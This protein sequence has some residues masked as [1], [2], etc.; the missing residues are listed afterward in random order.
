MRRPALSMDEE[1]LYHG[2]A[3]VLASSIVVSRTC[4]MGKEMAENGE[5]AIKPRRGCWLYILLIVFGLPVLLVGLAFA[6]L[7][8][9]DSAAAARLE[10]RLASI[11]AQGLPVD[12]ASLNT[13]Y[14]SLTSTDQTDAWLAILEEL[15][16]EA[17]RQSIEG[18]PIFDGKL[19]ENELSAEP[20]QPWPAEARTR[21]FLEQWSGLHDRTMRL[22]MDGKPT[23]WDL[24]FASFSTS[25]E[26]TQALRSAGRLLS[27]RGQLGLYDR[28]P[29]AVRRAVDALLGIPRVLEGEPFM[30]SQLVATALKGMG[31]ELLKDALQQGV[32]REQDL[33]ALLPKIIDRTKVGGSWQLSL[34]GER[35]M[36]LPVVRNPG[37]HD[38]GL[39]LGPRLP[40]RSNDANHYLDLLEDALEIHTEDPI[41]LYTKARELESKMNTEL[42]NMN[43]FEQLDNIMTSMVTPAIAAV[44]SAYS[45]SAIQFRIT[46]LAMAVRMYELEH[47]SLPE[48]LDDVQPYGVTAAEL[49]P[50]GGRPFG[51]EKRD[52]GSAVLWGFSL[53]SREYDSVPDF[54]PVLEIGQPNIDERQSWVFEFTP[55]K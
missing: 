1:S 46:A 47:G 22:S 8:W 12:D 35:A 54:P 7:G 13:Y 9:R 36:A 24:E 25:L 19:E 42:G 33:A 50:P 52:D 29:A 10:A 39:E 18:V 27:L 37:A 11:R 53:T 51:Y 48:S 20:G 32:L 23:R 4:R 44:A 14:Q 5:V 45:R 38:S 49:M 31:L 34:I 3:I 40:F 6:M 17:F 43:W 21:E 30:V 16:S 2:T 15:E 55:A 41:E 26:Q 28:D